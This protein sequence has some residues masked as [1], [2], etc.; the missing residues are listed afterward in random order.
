M[1]GIMKHMQ[2]FFQALLVV[3]V[4][5]G[6]IALPGCA[7]QT[8]HEE[9]IQEWLDKAEASPAYTPSV[10]PPDIERELHIEPFTYI[11]DVEQIEFRELPEQPLS[12][13]IHDAPIATILLAMA[14]AANINLVVSPKVR[15]ISGVSIHIDNVLW[16]NAFHTLLKTH[17]LIH[18]WEGDVIR[19]KTLDD[20][21]NDIELVKA[22]QEI[23]ALHT[24]KAQLDPLVTSLVKLNYI[25]IGKKDNKDNDGSSRQQSSNIV[26]QIQ[27][28]LTRIEDNKF[29]GAITPDSETNSLIIQASL[30][31]TDKIIRLLERIDRP[32][33]H[34]HIQA[35]I[36]ETSKNMARDL[37]FQWGGFRAGTISNQPYATYPGVGVGGASTFSAGF[38]QGIGGA[39]TGAQF[40]ADLG[41][42][43]LHWGLLIGSPNY[44]EVQLSALQEDGKLNILSSPSITTMDNLVAFT[45]SGDEVPYIERYDSSG[46]PVINYKEAV[47][48]LRITPSVI[49][50]DSLILDIK[51][52]KDEVDFSRAIGGNPFFLKKETQTKLVVGNTETV[53]ISGLT[54]ELATNRVEGVP[55]LKDIPGLGALLRRDRKGETM[56]EVLIF[57]TPTILP[58]RPVSHLSQPDEIAP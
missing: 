44:L 32:R 52:Q 34:I 21:K 45:K 31:D 15:E 50:R 57:I 56:E 9:R 13:K 19:V 38:N 30:K 51:V 24:K 16:S 17:G 36:V 37:G 29:H 1:T 8:P 54:K 5:S 43:G 40:P 27:T 20:V 22:T 10:V 28:Q 23:A 26:E 33:P 46:N 3:A 53:V 25:T 58:E 55:W 18:E 12:L 6:F 11:D 35:F 41:L 4:I 2:C 47:L 48:E 49:N 42:R 39:G 7:K 14:R